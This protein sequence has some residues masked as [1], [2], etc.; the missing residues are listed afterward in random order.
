MRL[1]LHLP[2]PY[3]AP[4]E[5]EVND[6]VKHSSVCRCEPREGA[7]ELG[8]QISEPAPSD[9]SLGATGQGT[10]TGLSQASEPPTPFST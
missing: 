3:G 9:D 8:V 4:I 10:A 5:V 1:R 7:Y 2:L 6:T